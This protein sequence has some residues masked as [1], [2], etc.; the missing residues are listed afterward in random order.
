[1]HPKALIDVPALVARQDEL[2]A[3]WHAEPVAIV[4]E[5]PLLRVI[6]DNHARNFEL[7]HQEDLARDAQA[8]DTVIAGVKRAIDTLN[9]VRNNAMEH[10]DEQVLS[11][12]PAVPAGDGGLPLHSETVG[13][14]VDRLSILS[15]RIFHMREQ[16]GRTDADERHIASCRAKLA[17][18]IEQRDDLAIALAALLDDLTAGHKRFK[19]Y[20]QMKMYNDPTLNPVLYGKGE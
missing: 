4:E 11:S 7:W 14:I 13:S 9:Q 19:V 8:D 2:V 10:V 18:L 3:R 12:L 20:R 15:L 16:T 6:L 17:V 1:M 5:I